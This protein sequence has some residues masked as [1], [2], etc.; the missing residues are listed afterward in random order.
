MQRKQRNSWLYQELQHYQ[1]FSFSECNSLLGWLS[2][3]NGRN[4]LSAIVCN[5]NFCQKDHAGYHTL[6]LRHHYLVIDLLHSPNISLKLQWKVLVVRG[7]ISVPFPF[8]RCH[9]EWSAEVNCRLPASYHCQGG[10]K[11]KQLASGWV[12]AYLCLGL[13]GFYC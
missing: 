4:C 10:C 7:F 12:S 6:S 5:S 9:T 13:A 1:L 3:S 8:L 2:A 11:E